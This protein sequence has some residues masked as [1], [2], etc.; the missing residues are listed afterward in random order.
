MMSARVRVMLVPLLALQMVARVSGA[1]M[2][3]EGVVIDSLRGP[4]GV[5]G[6]LV[7][8]EPGNHSVRTD[9]RG[10]FRISWDGRAALEISHRGA[11]L[12]SLGIDE[13]RVRIEPFERGSDSVSAVL[14]SPS[15]GTLQAAICGRALPDSVGVVMGELRHR[16][17]TVARAIEV[18][19]RWWVPSVGEGSH[20]VEWFGLTGESREDGVYAL[21]GV[22]VGTTI[23]LSA[24]GHS[25]V[26]A[27]RTAEIIWPVERVDLRVSAPGDRIQLRGRV[28]GSDGRPVT[29]ARIA[30]RAD[31]T[32]ATLSGLD[33]RFRLTDVPGHSGELEVRHV[34]HRP[35]VVPVDPTADVHELS[36]VRLA[37]TTLRLETVRVLARADSRE[38]AEFDRRRLGATG[39]FL[40]DSMLAGL[41]RVTL[42][43]AA[44]FAPRL[45]A[46]AQGRGGLQ[47]LMLRQGAGWCAPRF[48][49]DGIDVGRLDEVEQAPEQQM[50]VE[51]A[52]R[53][54]VYS[55]AQAPPQFNDN[56]GCGAVVVWTR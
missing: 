46:V 15:A 18:D 2:R 54:E 29:G 37:E 35:A 31:T 5:P 48:F 12:D 14:A 51:R 7:H 43:A 21:C 53:I 24:R 49:A 32:R 17:G 44:S 28:V 50:L 27:D 8:V 3:V 22:P 13:L 39:V 42:A 19:A 55:A 52:K 1:Q 9:D 4:R 33:G 26:S 45:R 38:L 11:W 40:T 23:V 30:W 16:D 10:R 25:A 47:R 34:A 41:P 36:D 20:R 56:D 6:V